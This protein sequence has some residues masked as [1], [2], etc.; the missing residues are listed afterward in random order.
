MASKKKT[1]TAL[2][3]LN[4]DVANSTLAKA[5]VEVKLT[6]GE[7]AEYIAAKAQK[8]ITEEIQSLDQKYGRYNLHNG[9]VK[10]DTYPKRIAAIVKSLTAADS[11]RTTQVFFHEKGYG[12]NSHRDRWVINSGGAEM[13]FFL[14]DDEEAPAQ[15]S[16]LKAAK[17]RFD[18]LHNKLRELQQKNYKVLLVESILSG[19]VAGATVLADLNKMVEQMVAAPATSN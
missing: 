2:T 9:V 1:T 11:E 12:W 14:N 16:E 19:S 7:I 10:V 18:T 6:K 13:A 17:E 15:S 4:G 3:T 5:G 8:Q